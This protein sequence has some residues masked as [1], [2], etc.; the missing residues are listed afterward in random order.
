MVL[1]RR[2]SK[3]IS[4]WLPNEVISEVIEAA[5][6]TDLTA[7]YRASQVSRPRCPR[8]VPRR[9]SHQVGCCEYLHLHERFLSERC[10]ECRPRTVGTV[11]RRRLLRLGLKSFKLLSRLETMWIRIS[12]EQDHLHMFRQWSFP[13]LVQCHVVL[14]SYTPS[15]HSPII[16]S[17]LSGHPGLTSFATPLGIKVVFPFPI[18]LPNLRKF[19]GPASLISSWLFLVVQDMTEVKLNWDVLELHYDVEKI[20]ISLKTMTNE[21]IPFIYSNNYVCTAQFTEI[22]GSLSR[23]I[24][25][26]RTVRM[27]CEMEVEHIA[28]ITKCLARFSGLVFL[29]IG[30]WLIDTYTEEDTRM[31]AQDFRC[32]C[33]SLEA[34]CIGIQEDERDV[35]RIYSA[36]FFS[37]GGHHF[38]ILFD[39][40]SRSGSINRGEIKE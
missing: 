29:S 5:P 27:S 34:C 39:V 26:A 1:T 36:R 35:G 13:R 33:P 18:S 17:F 11:A 14:S 31:V 12:L 38:V 24:P 30:S 20:I 25:Y 3:T 6:T 16:C 37:A 21:K 32:A 23:N 19:C 28:E 15:M 8:F 10:L 2:Q 40:Q 7:L 22:M 9:E 4:R